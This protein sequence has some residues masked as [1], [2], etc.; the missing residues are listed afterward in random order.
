MEK[1]YNNVCRE[2]LGRM[3][4]GYRVGGYLIRSMS[5]LYEDVWQQSMDVWMGSRVGNIFELRRGLRQG[6]VMSP[7]LFNIFFDKGARQVNERAMG[8]GRISR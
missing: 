8:R 2:E 3:L 5:S 1:M 4:Y 6:Y 7:W